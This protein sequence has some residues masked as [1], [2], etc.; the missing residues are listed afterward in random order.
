MDLSVSDMG[1]KNSDIGH[2]HLLNLTGDKG[3]IKQ[4]RHAR[5]VFLKIN[6]GH[7]GSRAP[8]CQNNS[9][10]SLRDHQTS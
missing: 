9:M 1:P 4:K 2:G 8:T 5:L 3:N 10:V 7:Q 6:M